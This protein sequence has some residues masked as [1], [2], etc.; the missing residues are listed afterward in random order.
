MNII[1]F[2][3]L[4]AIGSVIAVIAAIIQ[5]QRRIKNIN[6]IESQCEDII[7]LAKRIAASDINIEIHRKDII[8]QYSKRYAHLAE[9]NI[10]RGATLSAAY[11]DIISL[12]EMSLPVTKS[13][14]YPDLPCP[15]R[16]KQRELPAFQQEYL[17]VH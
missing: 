6:K 10:A 16:K 14:C 4:L 15:S 7:A 13:D 17:A 11:L 12:S 8:Q 9:V 5:H 2:S 1:V 3:I